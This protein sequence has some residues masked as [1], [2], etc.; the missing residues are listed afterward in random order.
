MPE[1]LEL[2]ESYRDYDARRTQLL[3]EQDGRSVR[4]LRRSDPRYLQ[5][6][7]E[8]ADFMD[9]VYS[10]R[11][12]IWKFQEA[13]TTS[14]FPLYFADVI[15]RQMLGVYNEWPLTWPSVA[16]RGTVPDFRSVKRF[17]FDGL[18]DRLDTVP[19]ETEYPEASMSET[20]YTYSVEKRG[21]RFP[22]AWETLV[23]DD[24]DGLKD[25]P[26]RFARAARRSEEH[27]VT[28]LYVDSSGPHATLYS[29]G[30]SNIVTS[31]PVLSIAALQTAMTVLHNQTDSDGEPI[32]FDAITLV[33][34]PAL[35]VTAQNIMNALEIRAVSSGGG[36]SAQTLV[37][38][39]WMAGRMTLEVNP[40]IPIVATS[41]GATSWF[42]FGSPSA[43][44]PAL[45]FGF[46]RGHESPEIFIKDSNQR[47]IGGGETSPM[48]G[49]F[50]TDTVQW[51]IRHVYGGTRLEPKST[52]GSNG[53]GS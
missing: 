29:V 41:N 39:N 21:R 8:A 32:F 14:D 24:L 46:L 53:S 25:A 10:G 40:Y 52:V 49:D 26:R 37:A 34:P 35:E 44:R 7:A 18:E 48:D 11:A 30:N 31:N 1:F 51:K 38:R 13:M 19:Q 3:T 22:I 12:P 33:V 16:R 28:S 20:Q 15:D 9:R 50:D 27:F 43:G 23:N 45:E 5:G 42:L 2:I 47:R 6:L 36:T 4:S 17:A